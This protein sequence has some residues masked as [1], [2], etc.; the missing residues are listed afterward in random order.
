MW[1]HE[2]RTPL[3][4]IEGTVDAI[5]DGVFQAD[6]E[7]LEVIKEQTGL[8]TRLVADLRDLSLAESGQLKLQLTRTDPVDMVNR[9][10]NEFG[11]GA[12]Q[13]N[14]RIDLVT[15]GKIPEIILDPIRTGQVISNLLSNS[16]RHTAAGGQ[17]TVT[18]KKED[19]VPGMNKPGLVLSVSDSGEGIP[20]EHLPFIF[21]RFYRVENSR[22]RD[23]GRG[24]VG[25]AIVKQ[26]VQA[27]NGIVWA[28]SRTGQGSTFYIALPAD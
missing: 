5:M 27:H 19:R 7:H 15:E 13:K 28:E 11:P 23:R 17:I 1:A 10:I 6:G 3:T 2:L 8:L 20:A 16:L 14:I 12:N 9:K 21:E 24:R 22:S 4:V 26:M 18:V 25:L